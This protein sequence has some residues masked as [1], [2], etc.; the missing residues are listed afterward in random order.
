M[1]T[2]NLLT[3][4]TRK[5]GLALSALALTAT[6]GCASAAADNSSAV[7]DDGSVDLSKVT[8]TVGDQKGGS[9]ALLEASGAIDELPYKVKWKEF[10]SGPPLLEAL[11]AGAIDVG[12][13]GNT[14]P[15]FA[16]ASNSKLVVVAGDTMGAKGDTI[17]VPKGSKIKDVGGLEGKKVAVAKGSSANYNLLAQLDKAGVAFDKVDVRYLQ[18]ADAL[19]AFSAGHVDAWAI[20]DPYTAQAEV[21]E[22]A[23]VIADGGGVVNG[24]AFQA[25]NPDS[26]DDKATAA[27]LK[28]Y[29]G[30]LAAAK[31]WSNTHREKWAK[32]WADETGLSPEV[33][34]RAV[35]RRVAR[36]TA[37]SDEVIASEQEM[38]DAFVAA[39]LLP[40]KFDVKPFFDNRYDDVVLKSAHKE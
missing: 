30:R 17:V 27:A 31:V 24:M 13:V 20:W 2:Q 18:P 33:T 37:L 40:E 32:V 34:S 12:A 39:K 22:K 21:D 28:D 4:L 5:G 36:P 38:A 10:T 7:R 6:A 19:A 1:R 16:A 29:V 9:K 8:I 35:N 14:P 15:L 26:L 23:K 11:N 3:T 25:A